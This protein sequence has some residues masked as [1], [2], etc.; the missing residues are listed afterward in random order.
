MRNTSTQKLDETQKRSG[1]KGMMTGVKRMRET[2]K[3]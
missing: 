3:K 1:E 2:P